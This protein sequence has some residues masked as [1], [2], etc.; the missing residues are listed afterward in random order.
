VYSVEVDARS[1]TQQERHSASSA[2]LFVALARTSHVEHSTESPKP[3][4]RHCDALGGVLAVEI[5]S[6]GNHVMGFQLW[7]TT[8]CAAR[9]RS[10]Y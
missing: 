5:N 8:T 6:K 4:S 10:N 3:S 2:S 9:V 7:N 1:L